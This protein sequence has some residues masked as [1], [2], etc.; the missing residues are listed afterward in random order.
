MDW[1]RAGTLAVRWRKVPGCEKLSLRS[2]AHLAVVHAS[3]HR[4]IVLPSRERGNEDRY[5]H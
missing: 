4:K 1:V 5:L 3:I 2:A